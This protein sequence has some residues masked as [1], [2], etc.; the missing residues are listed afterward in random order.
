MEEN[1]T[2]TRENQEIDLSYLWKSFKNFFENIVYGIFKFISFFLRNIIATIIL[3]IIGIGL[4]VYMYQNDKGAYR[5]VVVVATNFG[6]TEYAYNKINNFNKSEQH[7]FQ[8]LEH[9]SK[10]DIEPIIDIYSFLSD[11]KDNLD[12]AKYMSENTIEVS[13]YKDDNNVEK[14]YRYHKIEY[15]TDVADTDN[16]IYNDLINY[17]NNDEYYAQVR[18]IGVAESQNRLAELEKSVENIN[19]VFESIGANRSGGGSGDIKIDLYSQIN[20]LM[21]TKNKLL[22]QITKT[23][24]QIVEEEKVVYDVSSNR[25]LHNKSIIKPVLPTVA[26]LLI[27]FFVAQTVKRY[28]KFRNEEA[29][30]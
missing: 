7:N 29:G 16:G 17:L 11:E 4:G 30:K 24:V 19:A 15:L 22:R 5:N 21:L 26:L 14:L 10:I 25:N 3:L 27:F 28:K 2:T 12:M 20:E 8:G 18:K 1:K 6:S 23:K 9:V 13:K